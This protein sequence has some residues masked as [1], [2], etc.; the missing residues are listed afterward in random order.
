MKPSG[1]NRGQRFEVV[2][3]SSIENEEETASSNQI[4][5]W[6]KTEV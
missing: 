6:V 5:T 1:V 4:Q 3:D 2:S